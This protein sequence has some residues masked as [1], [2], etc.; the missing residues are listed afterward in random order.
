MPIQQKAASPTLI[1][2]AEGHIQS[3]ELTLV[4]IEEGL[5]F[6]IQELLLMCILSAET[7]TGEE[8]S[9]Y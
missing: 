5:E 9:V 1:A 7:P 3:V 8:S 6:H 2:P 4:D